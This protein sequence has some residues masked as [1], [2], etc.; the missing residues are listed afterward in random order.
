MI[1]TLVMTL[2]GADRPGL[3]EAVAKRVADHGGNWLESR[4]CRLG[5][6]FAGIVRV[7]VPAES[8]IPLRDVLAALG[9]EGLSVVVQAEDPT[10]APPASADATM[11]GVL[12]LVELVGHDRPGIVRAVSAV[13]ARHGANV[14]EFSSAREGAPMGGGIL[15]QA[16]ASIR[17]PA[18]VRLVALRADLEQIAADLMVDLH[19]REAGAGIRP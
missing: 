5:G 16:R 13:F 3:V 2:I 18:N 11:G 10:A 17:V 7:E 9:A 14:E 8:Q 6:R 15:F 19:L 12:A 1:Q 4:M